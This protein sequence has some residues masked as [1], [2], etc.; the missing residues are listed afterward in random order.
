MI[1]IFVSRNKQETSHEVEWCNKYLEHIKNLLRTFLKREINIHDDFSELN[2]EKLK[3]S[4]FLVFNTPQYLSDQKSSK[5][6]DT[7]VQKCN[8][9]SLNDRIFIINRINTA[10]YAEP[11]YDDYK[12]Y[13]FFIYDHVS[14]GLLELK[15]DADSRTNRL[16]WFKLVDITFDIK[17]SLEKGSAKSKKGAK[18]IFLAE[19]S[20]DQLV[21]RDVVKRELMHHGYTV[22]PETA[23]PVE[24][25]ELEKELLDYLSK[26][27]L[28]IHIIGEDNG[29]KINGSVNSIV[30]FQN[31]IAASYSQKLAEEE[32][33][34]FPRLI[35]ISRNLRLL[36]EQQ[37]VYI[38]QLKKDTEA[39]VGAEIV[40]TPLEVF[41]Q[42]I[43][44]K[45]LDEYGDLSYNKDE[46][47]NSNLPT[48]YVIFDEKSS[49][50]V[51]PVIDALK[52]RGYQ[53]IIPGFSQKMSIIQTHRQNLVNCESTIIFYDN[54]NLRW[55][56]SKVKDLVKAPGFGRNKAILSSLIIN[57]SNQNLDFIREEYN[58]LN[59][60]IVKE[61]S[62]DVLDPFLEKI[63]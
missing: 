24:S 17:A 41:K 58:T 20:A 14:A 48:I 30:D 54:N 8:E 21:T 36:D 10:V 38:E 52:S 59:I 35:W 63:K 53:V 37:H 42:I 2:G 45:I 50:K 11:L 26:S 7:M 3:E 61:F 31:L 57:N 23:L 25:S 56:R 32:N 9:L 39:L 16:Y 51:E 43:R 18:T 28:S 29:R 27:C 40:Q 62:K 44:E 4:I 5:E 13:E 15:D 49:S 6:F 47:S 55:L 34:I 22:L 60:Q 1:N 46:K 19:T 12:F 33:R